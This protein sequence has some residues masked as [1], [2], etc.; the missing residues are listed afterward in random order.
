MRVINKKELEDRNSN[1]LIKLF[2]L[3]K[4]GNTKVSNYCNRYFKPIC[5]N[6]P[7]YKK[8]TGA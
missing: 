5:V 6:N 2:K 4:D 1:I 8:Q 3:S 7:D